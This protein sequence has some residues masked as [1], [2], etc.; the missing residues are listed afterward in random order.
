MVERYVSQT[1]KASTKLRKSRGSLTDLTRYIPV[2]L[3]KVSYEA[4]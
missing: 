4:G 2:S 1:R 3:F